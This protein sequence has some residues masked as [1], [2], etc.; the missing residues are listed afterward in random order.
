[1]ETESNLSDEDFEKLVLDESIDGDD[2]LPQ[3]SPR[4]RLVKA[5]ILDGELE[6]AE[7]NENDDE[8][9]SQNL[10]ILSEMVEPLDEVSV[11]FLLKDTVLDCSKHRHEE[12]STN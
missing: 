9:Q 11:F 3:T 7:T 8:L 5:Q 4:L 10:D 6:L 12:T 2:G 1:M